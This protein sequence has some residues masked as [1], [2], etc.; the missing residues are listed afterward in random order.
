M[1]GFL[2]DIS[3]CSLKLWRPSYSWV[4]A[5]G[6]WKQLIIATATQTIDTSVYPKI[7]RENPHSIHQLTILKKTLTI[8]DPM[9]RE[10]SY[11]LVVYLPLWKIWK[12]VGIII[13]NMMGKLFPIWWEKYKKFQTTNQPYICCISNTISPLFS[14]KISL[15]ENHIHLMW[16]SPEETAHVIQV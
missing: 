6:T 14:I 16:W 3:M 12:S 4:V 5:L 10:K 7:W 1:G 13:P 15:H 8:G 2:V 11:R 9:D